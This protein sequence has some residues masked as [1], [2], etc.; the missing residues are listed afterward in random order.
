MKELNQRRLLLKQ[1]LRERKKV[2]AAWNSLF[3]PSITEIFCKAGIDFIFTIGALS[4]HTL[5]AALSSGM[6]RTSAFVCKNHADAALALRRLAKRGDVVLV[7]GSRAM[8]ME[9]VIETFKAM[10]D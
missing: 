9:K 4:R 5:R 1:S 7:K 8:R 2:F 6:N 10:A 3:H